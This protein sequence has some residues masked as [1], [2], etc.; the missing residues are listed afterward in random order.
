[1]KRAEPKMTICCFLFFLQFSLRKEEVTALSGP[2]E[3]QEF[4]T[5]FNAIKAFHKKHPNEASRT[6]YDYK[7][8]KDESVGK[9][10]ELKNW[11]TYDMLK[12]KFLKLFFFYR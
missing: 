8:D 4:Y 6:M 1:M 7:F 3:F 12:A 5:R 2:N 10:L 11:H 9:R